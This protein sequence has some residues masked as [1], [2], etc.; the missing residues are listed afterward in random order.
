MLISG[1]ILFILLLFGFVV[2][3]KNKKINVEWRKVFVVVFILV[4]LVYLKN[5]VWNNLPCNG[6]FRFFEIKSLTGEYYNTS[7]KQISYRCFG[8]GMYDGVKR[9]NNVS[10]N[11]LI[12]S[13]EEPVVEKLDLEKLGVNQKFLDENLPKALELIKKTYRI[14]N[15]QWTQ[16]HENLYKKKFTDLERAK[17]LV[18]QS[19]LP[20]LSHVYGSF[21]FSIVTK[22]GRKINAN[23]FTQKDYMIPWE[24]NLDGKKYE[25]FNTSI[26]KALIKLVP[27]EFPNRKWLDGNIFQIIY[28]AVYN[29]LSNDSDWQLLDA[30]NLYTKELQLLESSYLVNDSQ[31]KACYWPRPCGFF[32]KLVSKQNP[33]ISF[34]TVFTFINEEQRNINIEPFFAKAKYYEN[35]VASIDWINNLVKS[36]TST[37]IVIDMV[38]DISVYGDEAKNEIVDLQ[39]CGS[40]KLIGLIN[41]NK[42]NIV[43][44]NIYSGPDG[45]KKGGSSW[46][47]LP[48]KRSIFVGSNSENTNGSVF[49][50]LKKINSEKIC[51]CRYAMNGSMATGAIFE[52][53]GAAVSAYQKESQPIKDSDWNPDWEC[54]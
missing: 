8:D 2:D 50:Y 45:G 29:E 17:Y 24:V 31:A 20:D 34:F 41:D 5:L 15:D 43:N 7:E 11:E 30:K 26:S 27:E 47:I 37:E 39:R 35:Q 48:D 6:D 16:N 14:N 23:S 40:A 1:L 19:Y 28:D 25:T 49:S 10:I 32:V 22:D 44:L 52:L 54:L 46:M 33:H 42:D 38:N 9:V 21:E 4:G 12:K 18:E 53:N 3:Y 36:D 51:V 13:I